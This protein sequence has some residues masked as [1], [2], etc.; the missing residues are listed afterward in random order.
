[1]RRLKKEIDNAETDNFFYNIRKHLAYHLC[2]NNPQTLTQ[3]KFY[4]DILF[5]V[6][7]DSES[8]K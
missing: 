5:D 3:K 7:H 8:T 1:M 6:T 2:Y 4:F